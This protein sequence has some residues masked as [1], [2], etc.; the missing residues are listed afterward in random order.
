MFP[1]SQSGQLSSEQSV[2]GLHN[3]D[4]KV[5]TEVLPNLEI[6]HF[7]YHNHFPKSYI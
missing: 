3:G 5:S 2:S 4:F 6:Q 7:S 1:A